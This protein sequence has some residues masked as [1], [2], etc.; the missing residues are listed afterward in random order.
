MT[1]AY[2]SGD[3]GIRGGIKW[4]VPSYSSSHKHTLVSGDSDSY[5]LVS[6]PSVFLR[7]LP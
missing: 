6:M 4:P 3:T 7:Y 5:T 1:H 2:D